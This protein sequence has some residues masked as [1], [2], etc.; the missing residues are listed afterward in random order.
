MNADKKKTKQTTN[1]SLA[2]PSISLEMSRILVLLFLAWTVGA[3]GVEQRPSMA[4]VR[5]SGLIVM[6][7][8]I[9]M[10]WKSLTKSGCVKQRERVPHTFHR[11]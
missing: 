11:V 1:K 3:I 6:I 2:L 8:L 4:R 5:L 9:V 7:R 10:M